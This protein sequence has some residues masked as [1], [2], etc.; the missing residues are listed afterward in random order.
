MQIFILV[1]TFL[2]S[3]MQWK[4]NTFLLKPA[5]FAIA[6]MSKVIDVSYCFLIKENT[7]HYFLTFVLLFYVIKECC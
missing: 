6:S 7:H 4:I 1:N 5:Y 3:R 2:A